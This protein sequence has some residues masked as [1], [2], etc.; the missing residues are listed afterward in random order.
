M[1]EMTTLDLY[2]HALTALRKAEAIIITDRA[3]SNKPCPVPEFNE[4]LASAR[5]AIR[6][7]EDAIRQREELGR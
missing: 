3:L 7:F 4:A 2:R 6:T 5:K 1:K